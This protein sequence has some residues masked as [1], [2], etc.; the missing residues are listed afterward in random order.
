MQLF[1]PYSSKYNL[2]LL[3]FRSTVTILNGS[4]MLMMIFYEGLDLK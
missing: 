4:A 1:L 3:T 2:A